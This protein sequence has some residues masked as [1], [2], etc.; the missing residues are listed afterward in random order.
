MPAPES[1]EAAPPPMSVAPAPVSANPPARADATTS[2]AKPVELAT[3]TAPVATPAVPADHATSRALVLADGELRKLAPGG[4]TEVVTAV[5]GVVGCD[6]DEDH[7]V[8]WLA[9]ARDLAAYDLSDGK[10]HPVTKGAVVVDDGD[11]LIWRVRHSS[12]PSPFPREVAGNADGLEHCVAL[13]VDVDPRPSVGGMVVAEGDREFSC[14]VSD[15]EGDIVEGKLD[16]DEAPRKKGYDR[17]TLVDSKFLVA[18]A[19]RRTIFPPEPAAP[20]PPAPKVKVDVDRCT[21]DAESCGRAEYV[22]G[23]RLWWIVVG[24]SRGDFFHE[25]RLLYDATTR[26]WWDPVHDRRESKPGEGDEGVALHASPD[27]SWGLIEGKILSL[28][29]A[30]ITGRWSG[31]FCGWLR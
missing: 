7:G 5:P 6:F 16:V 25:Q 19:T 1:G 22:G 13:V 14:F 10:V 21:E 28:E 11:G 29:D 20:A 18:L 27:R 8:V 30:A 12:A 15:A 2:T 26:T 9:S 4:T 31:S 17:A 24:N 3:P 23:Q